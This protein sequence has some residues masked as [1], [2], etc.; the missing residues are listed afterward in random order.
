[1]LVD[2]HCAGVYLATLLYCTL[3]LLYDAQRSLQHLK[4]AAVSFVAL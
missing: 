3:Q 1:M 4:V 2:A